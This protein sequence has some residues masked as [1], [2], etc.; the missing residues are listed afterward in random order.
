MKIL[1]CIES[2]KKRG[3]GLLILLSIPSVYTHRRDRSDMIAHWQ[4]F[5]GSSHR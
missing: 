3:M 4:I 5:V 1:N 2:Y